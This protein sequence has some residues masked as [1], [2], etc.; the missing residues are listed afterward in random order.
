MEVIK[1]KGKKTIVI[2]LTKAELNLA[3]GK[4]NPAL[5]SK[6]L[7]SRPGIFRIWVPGDF[8]GPIF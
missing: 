2:T 7:S 1:V 4:I 3:G 5:N 8:S 6:E